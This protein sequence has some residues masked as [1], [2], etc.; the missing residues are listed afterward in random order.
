MPLYTQ[1]CVT[2]KRECAQEASYQRM[3][4]DDN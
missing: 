1:K 3:E 4:R 2:L